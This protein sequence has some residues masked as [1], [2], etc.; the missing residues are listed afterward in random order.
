MFRTSAL[1]AF[2]TILAL[3][4]A[5][6]ADD[7]W[8]SQLEV[9]VFDAFHKAN[10]G[11]FDLQ[12]RPGWQLMNFGVFGGLMG[13]TQ[14]ALYGYAGITYDLKLGDHWLILPDAAVGIYGNGDGKKLGNEVEFR[15][16]IAIAY[17]FDNG[18][19]A[20]VGLHH[21]SNAGLGK[22]NPGVEIAAVSLA[23]PLFGPDPANQP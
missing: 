19:R 14:S 15:T 17:Q 22:L 11:A 3:A 8:R 12:L 1:A 6:H 16:G 23:I 5:A 21:I 18:W 2:A 13:T 10:A 9:G 4:P 7:L 20:G